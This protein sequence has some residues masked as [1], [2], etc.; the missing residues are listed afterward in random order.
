MFEQ[1]FVAEAA[2]D[3]KRYTV[4]VGLLLEVATLALLII[5]P[6][7]YTQVLPPARLRSVFAAPIPA[8]PDLPKAPATIARPVVTQRRFTQIM[9]VTP[10]PHIVRNT[11]VMSAA[12]P[13]AVIGAPAGTDPALMGASSDWMEQIK[14]PEPPPRPSAARQPVNKRVRLSSDVE[15]SLLI[16]KV[17]PAYPALARQVR[18]QGRVE[19]TAVIGKT[20]TIENLQLLSGHPMLVAA[21]RDAILQWRYKPTLLNGEPVEVITDIVVNF[22]LNEQ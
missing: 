14:L 20:G 16:H 8:A 7:I 18:V 10:L 15:A 3:K 6:L 2:N 9:P 22:A 13:D 17:Q 21:A 19:F 4:L 11:E 12:P 1:T 5:V